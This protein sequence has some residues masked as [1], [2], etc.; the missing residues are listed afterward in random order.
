MVDVSDFRRWARDHPNFMTPD[1]ISVK[2]RGNRFIEL[3]EGTDF[4]HNPM[5]GVTTIVWTGKEFESRGGKPFS[6]K[7]AKLKALKHFRR[8]N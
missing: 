4:D 7:G 3:S 1:I 8:T 2:K 6:G 5:Y